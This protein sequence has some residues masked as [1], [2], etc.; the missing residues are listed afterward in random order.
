MLTAAESEFLTA[1]DLVA[2]TGRA[3][4]KQQCAVLDERGIPYL[5]GAKGRPQVSRL[6]TRMIATGQEVRQS[7]GPNWSAVK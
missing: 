3:H 5:V 7:V 4:A 6:H 2:L 1:A